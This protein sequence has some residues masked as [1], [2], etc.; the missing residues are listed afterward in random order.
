MFWLLFLDLTWGLLLSVLGV[1]D[2]CSLGL[3]LGF[4]V[5]GVWIR[6]FGGALVWVVCLGL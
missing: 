3:D 1:Y 5:G 2:C 4:R 6:L